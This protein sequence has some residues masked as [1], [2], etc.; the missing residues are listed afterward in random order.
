MRRAAPRLTAVVLL[1]GLATAAAAQHGVAA[2]PERPTPD[3]VRETVAR[4]LSADEYT[5]DDAQK[6][7]RNWLGRLAEWLAG[8]FASASDRLANV[9]GPAFWAV[10]A[11]CMLGL[12]L[13]FYHV[14][15]ILRR[16]LR[17][18]V[19][20]PGRA[21]GSEADGVLPRDPAA[22]RELA[23]RHA[24]EGDYRMA[25]RRLYAAVLVTMDRKGLVRYA[26]D[27]T[28]WE[29]VR[30]A[31]GSAVQ[32]EL[33]TLTSVFDRKWYGREGWQTGE[34]DECSRLVLS[35]IAEVTG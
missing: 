4:V 25:F 30:E 10:I 33:R 5:F 35:V 31:A 20:G 13:I 24:R 17:V 29:Y 18:R 19:S 26:A 3:V 1:C 21:P 6:P 12:A 15:T 28:N 22:L 14:F 23:A 2:Q 9:S 11:A 34:Y 8:A 32:G 7:E 16:A 27:K